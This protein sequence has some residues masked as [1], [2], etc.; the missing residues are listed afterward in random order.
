MIHLFF[1]IALAAQP[2]PSP[3]FGD[4]AFTRA[5]EES[6]AREPGTAIPEPFASLIGAMGQS[7]WRK[8]E[9][10]SHA[11]QDASASDL[12]WL[13]WGR[14]HPDL[15]VRV[16]CNAIIRRL[17]PCAACKGSGGSRSWEGSACWECDG[18]GTEWPYTIWD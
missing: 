7:D 8:R 9:A 13:F 16:R 11:M 17:N 1:A 3:V 4:L 10:A 14:R 18:A 6:I 5:V 2:S 12:R 15:E